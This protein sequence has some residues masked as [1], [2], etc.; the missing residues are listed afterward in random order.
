MSEKPTSETAAGGPGQLTLW[1]I[2]ANPPGRI[3]I[4][5]ESTSAG[6]VTLCGAR[7]PEDAD[8]LTSRQP[9]TR[10]RNP[11]APMCVTCLRGLDHTRATSKIVPA[12]AL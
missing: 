4:E 2:L 9:E 11:D 12:A 10:V 6:V 3:H 5:D 1:R 8:A 7:I